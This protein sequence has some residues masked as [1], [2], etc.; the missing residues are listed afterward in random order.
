SSNPNIYHANAT[1]GGG[2]L[3]GSIAGLEYDENGDI[4][5]F[6]P[7]NFALGFAS[8]ALASKGLQTSAKRLEKL[9]N[10]NP[11]AKALLERIK[12]KHTKNQSNLATMS[13]QKLAKGKNMENQKLAQ[14]LQILP[15]AEARNISD[16][17]IM[18]NTDFSK[19]NQMAKTIIISTQDKQHIR[20]LRTKARNAIN[21]II[22]Q[23]II[24]K[25]DGRVAQISV[26]GRDKI[27]SGEA[28]KKSIVNGFSKEEH[29][30]TAQKLKELYKNAILQ[31]SHKDTKSK[32]IKQTHRYLANTIINNKEAQALLTIREVIEHGNRIY[33]LELQELRPMPSAKLTPT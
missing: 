6:N 17:D 13:N 20:E 3:G 33:S 24:N 11:K 25:N 5:G 29:F 28:L 1:L 23:Q 32:D 15:S 7:Q 12:T 2:V 30:N 31:N 22:N 10:R 19:G 26:N 21:T 9:A 16:L 4:K 8:G 14:A 27:L 18:A